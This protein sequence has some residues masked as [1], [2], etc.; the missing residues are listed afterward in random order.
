M[1]KVRQLFNA[2]DVEVAKRRRICHHNRRKHEI[3]Q[4]ERCLV[5]R[6]PDGGHKNYCVACATEILDWADQDLQALRDELTG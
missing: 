3:A 5:I 1:P 6:S 4:G 2:V